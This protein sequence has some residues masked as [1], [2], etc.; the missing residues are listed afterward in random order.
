MMTFNQKMSYMQ[1]YMQCQKMVTV[2]VSE[3]A[4]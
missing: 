2:Y 3:A 4:V 1:G